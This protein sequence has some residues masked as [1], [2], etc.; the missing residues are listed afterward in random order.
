M[1]QIGKMMKDQEIKKD[2]FGKLNLLATKNSNIFTLSY[3]KIIK[4]T[5]MVSKK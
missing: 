4:I 5:A 2:F 3:A 1:K